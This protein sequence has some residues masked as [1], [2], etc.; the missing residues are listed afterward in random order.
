M[1][2]VDKLNLIIFI[3]TT[4]YYGPNCKYISYEILLVT[5]RIY[6][7]LVLLSDLSC[8]PYSLL[9]DIFSGK[10]CPSVL[11]ILVNAFVVCFFVSMKFLLKEVFC[12]RI[13]SNF[14]DIFKQ[15]MNVLSLSKFLE[16]PFLIC[17]KYLLF[18]LYHLAILIVVIAQNIIN[19]LNCQ[20]PIN[21]FNIFELICDKIVLIHNFINKIVC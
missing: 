19:L 5:V 18:I 16:D 13:I 10:L 8:Q 20:G 3:C 14:F 1:R 12:F 6:S 17:L 15:I 9:Y 4:L 2:L 7:F 21:S 11:L